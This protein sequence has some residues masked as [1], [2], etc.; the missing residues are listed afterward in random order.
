M[1]WRAASRL[2][3]QTVW[4]WAF[5]AAGAIA[6]RPVWLAAARLAPACL[7]HA[8]TGLPCPGCGTTRA[9]VHLLNGEVA[10]GFA[11]N[12][13]AALGAAGFVAGGL[14]AP[15]WLVLGGGIPVVPHRPHPAFLAGA[16][17]AVALNWAWLV[18]S[19]V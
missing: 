6:L 2:D 12:P 19:G 15:L 7:W 9:L 10:A 4:L 16:A 14:L 17:A 13:L 1:N 11:M 5:A 8:W 18:A 3:R